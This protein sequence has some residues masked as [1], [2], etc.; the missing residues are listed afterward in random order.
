[1]KLTKP[2]TH[3]AYATFDSANGGD[4][5]WRIGKVTCKNCLHN[6]AK[7]LNVWRTNDP[8]TRV[9]AAKLLRKLKG[10]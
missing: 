10:R 3:Y 2:P 7:G 9:Q 1:M 8:R 6:V 4:V 5:A